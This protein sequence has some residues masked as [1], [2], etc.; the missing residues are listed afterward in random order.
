MLGF[1]LMAASVADAAVT[2]LDVSLWPCGIVPYTFDASMLSS[3]RA[4]FIAALNEWQVNTDLKFVLIPDGAPS[5]YNT[6]IVVKKVS[7]REQDVIGGYSTNVGRSRSSGPQQIVIFLGDFQTYRHEV[8]HAL[9]LYHEHSRPDG[10]QV[11]AQYMAN[12]AEHAGQFVLPGLEWPLTAYDPYSIVHYAADV[13]L[14]PDLASRDGASKAVCGDPTTFQDSCVLTLQPTNVAIVQEQQLAQNVIGLV[15]QVST[16]DHT[17]IGILYPPG[18]HGSIE[19]D[20]VASPGAAGT[21]QFVTSGEDLGLADTTKKAS[22]FQRGAIVN[23]L[24]TPDANSVFSGWVGVDS[25]DV[26]SGF[27]Q[28]LADRNTAVVAYFD[29][30]PPPPPGCCWTWDPTANGGRGGWVWTGPGSPPPGG[31]TRPPTGCWHWDASSKT[32]F[33]DICRSPGGPV[34]NLPVQIIT[35]GDPNDKVGSPGIGSAH[36]LPGSQRIYYPISFYNDI[37]ATAPAQSVNVTDPLNGS[38]LDLNTVA[39]GPI[40]FGNTVITP[41]SAPVANLGSYAAAVDL[42]P[43]MNLIVGITAA[44]NSG[45]GALT[46]TFRSLDPTTNLPTTNPLAGFLPP[47]I[48]GSVSFSVLARQ[49]VA[50]GTQATNQATVV[51]DANAPVNTPTWINTIDKTP[52][53]SHV[54]ALL[55]AST[56]PVLRVSWSGSDVGSGLQGFTVF[57]SD[58]GGPFTPWLS[59]ATAASADYIGTVGHTYSFYSV[60]TN[61]VG[62][63]EGAKTTA[64]ASTSV[65]ASGPCGA[66]SLSGQVSNVSQSGTTVTANLTLAN[67]GF[68]AAQTVNLNQ[69]TLRSLGGTG[70][71]ALTSPTLPRAVGPLAIGATTAVPL[72]FTVPS[73]VTRFSVTEGGIVQ[74]ASGNSYSFSIAQTI[75]P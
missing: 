22:C 21:V 11:N 7:G 4:S 64:E 55:A 49:S 17:G 59:N 23:V 5:P 46:W 34:Y 68:T 74:D 50:T 19:I 20:T 66:P 44:L 63:V 54:S 28:T 51:F 67:V 16:L 40:N 10:V 31:G 48:E 1:L 33:R 13:L 8:G 18:N 29:P 24:A 37:T 27:I 47:G 53:V 3:D 25:Q 58:T 39:L 56:C 26:D 52:P 12:Y 9:G 72:T 2:T 62:N 43:T 65:T 14:S 42:R 75:I 6:Y 70:A 60:A 73:T 15:T 45:T 38:V 41:P 35:S 36:Y 71:V 57:V 69:I 30:I 61:L 32:W